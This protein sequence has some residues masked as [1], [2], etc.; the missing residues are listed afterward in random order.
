MT[1]ALAFDAALAVLS[2]PVVLAS[3]Y[4]LALAAASGRPRT[5]GQPPALPRFDLLIPAHD[6][7]QGIAAT[8]E[9]LLGLDYARDA[10]RVWVVADN[11]TD[12]TAQ[13]A[14]ESGARVLE[15]ND[16]A[17][18]GKGYALAFGFE[19]LLAEGF[20]D[21]VVVV[22]ADTLASPNLLRAFAA[23]LAA[24]AQVLQADYRVRNPDASWRTRLLAI[25]FALVNTLRA[26]GRDRLGCSVGLR[27][28]GM[29]FATRLLRDV[30][31]DAFSVVEDL[32]YG[33]RLGEAG[34]RVHFVPE[35]CVLGEMPSGEA[36][37]RSQRRRWEQGRA[38]IARRRGWPLLRRGLAQR[39]RVLVELALDLLVPPLARVGA[40][41]VAGLAV[42]AG[43]AIWAGR[44][45]VAVVPWAA[46]LAA[47]LIYVARGWWLSGTGAAGLLALARAPLYLA[48]K[49][50]LAL[51][52]RAGDGWVRTA[53]EAPRGKPD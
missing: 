42:A 34:H 49:I 50:G 51:A 4:L 11:C 35:A 13:R 31:H 19:R 26:L 16:P 14:R 5:P 39:D 41:T 52:P 29:C 53:R 44:P 45:L 3:G 47:I 33:I 27:G 25:A 2:A 12:G 22:D 15:R 20:A 10:F 43:A 9:S 40:A 24:G 17:L 8:V 30:P 37:S 36:A 21:A 32:E 7:E 23:R 6:E 38:E 28:N 46:S 18:R 1:L 48:W